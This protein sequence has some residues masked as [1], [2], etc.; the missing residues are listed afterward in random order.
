LGYRHVLLGENLRAA[1]MLLPLGAAQ[2]L[3]TISGQTV[4]SSMTEAA[5]TEDM[6]LGS[7]K[8]EIQVKL[9]GF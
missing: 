7:F 2:T 5:N 6:N 1:K 3:I 9:W 8:S 4:S